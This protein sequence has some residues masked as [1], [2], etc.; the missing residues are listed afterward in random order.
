M[1]LSLVKKHQSD[2]ILSVE[3]V[4]ILRS[5]ESESERFSLDDMKNLLKMRKALE[6]EY[7]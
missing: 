5:A 1:N 3:E 2:E 6:T 4:T 7:V